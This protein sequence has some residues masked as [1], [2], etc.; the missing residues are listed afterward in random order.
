MTRNIL[1]AMIFFAAVL[2]PFSVF[3]LSPDEQ[4]NINIYEEMGS[5]VVNVTTTIVSYDFFFNPIPEQ[6]TGSGSI[7]DRKGHILTNFHVVENA[8][9][10]EVTLFDGSKWEA[11][12]VGADPSNDIAIIEIKAPISEPVPFMHS[13]A[14]FI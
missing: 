9:K 1:R 6:G 11:K 2:L 4:E 7:I 13:Y 14:F 3:A 12:L 5:G 8:K 10:L